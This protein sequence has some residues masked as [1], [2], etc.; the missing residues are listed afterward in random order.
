MSLMKKLSMIWAIGITV[1]ATIASA[2][3][4]E[5]ARLEI[6]TPFAGVPESF[7]ADSSGS[8]LIS[9]G[10]NRSITLWTRTGEKTWQ[11]LTLKAPYRN[12]FAAGAYVG[13][14]APDAKY[15]AF[16]V[17]PLANDKGGYEPRTAQIYLSLI[18]I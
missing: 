4:D 2:S 14:I 12:E 7:D 9:T 16:G 10:S 13:A 8:H 17:P 6:N 1:V 15:V 5:P 11:P 3:A 18:H